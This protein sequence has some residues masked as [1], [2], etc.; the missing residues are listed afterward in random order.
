MQAFENTPGPGVRCSGSD[1]IAVPG[2][3]IPTPVN[4]D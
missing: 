1:R 2:Q 3:W 4:T